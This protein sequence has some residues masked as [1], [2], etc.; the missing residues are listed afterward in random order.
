MSMHKTLMSKN[1]DK[2]IVGFIAKL[3]KRL[4]GRL[5]GAIQYVEHQHRQTSSFIIQQN[6]ITFSTSVQNYRQNSS[7]L[8]FLRELCNPS[9]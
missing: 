4:A 1:V 8:A 2:L 6:K 7:M 3:R 9:Y 5:L